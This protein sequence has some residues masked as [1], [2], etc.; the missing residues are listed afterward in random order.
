MEQL[1]FST[2]WN[3]KLT[4]NFYTTL[5]LASP[6]YVVGKVFEVS[7]ANK[8][9]HK[10]QVA[11]VKIIMLNQLNSYVCGLD[12]GYSVPATKEIIMRMYPGKDWSQQRLVLVL[13]QVIKDEKKEQ[14]NLQ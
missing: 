12:T 10:A 7:L 5:R 3:N 13:L 8:F 2:N 6:K 14:P 1:T 9:I 4:G 11:D